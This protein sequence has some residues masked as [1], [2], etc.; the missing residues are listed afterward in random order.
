MHYRIEV[1]GTQSRWFEVRAVKK[2]AMTNLELRVT[3]PT[4]TKQADVE[5][6]VA[7]TPAS[8]G[9]TATKADTRRSPFYREA[10]SNST[11]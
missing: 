8:P 11:R 4:Y 7:A 1:G 5:N 2:I 3:P 10:R 6:V 9:A